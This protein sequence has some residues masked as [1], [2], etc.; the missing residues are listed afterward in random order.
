MYG[1]RLVDGKLE[2]VPE[3]AEVLR[4][5]ADLYLEGYG[6]V[7]LERVLR[8]AGVLGRQG[9]F[10]RGSEVIDLLCNEKAAGDML[11]QKTFVSDPV[12][13]VGR[14]NKGELPQYLVKES[15][16]PILD[17]QTYEKILAERA[18]RAAL[19]QPNPKPPLSYPFTGL[20]TC[21]K[22]G[23]HF[24]RKI[25]N[26]GAGG[27]YQRPVWICSTFNTRG[28]AHCASKQ[29]PEGILKSVA[30]QAMDLPVF[31]E[32]A[33]AAQI[34]KIQVPENGVLVFVFRDGRSITKTWENR[35]R[36]ESWNQENREKARALSLKKAAERRA[37]LCR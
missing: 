18:R 33:F 36:R 8:K 1:Y 29:I 37:A 27:K 26:A 30:A 15:H 7:S 6:R 31:D 9:H 28:K 5:A 32:A 14:I 23:A 11:L 35:S 25:A 34:E 2:I 12:T 24:R 13:K 22:C 20:L 16:E 21:G 10:M 4:L 3:E 19:Y 17:R